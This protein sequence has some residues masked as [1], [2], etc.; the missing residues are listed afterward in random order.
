MRCCV[1]SRA[2]AIRSKEYAPR[3]SS[4]PPPLTPT[5]PP[6]PATGKEC[7]IIDPVDLTVGRDVQLLQEMGLKPAYA[8][9]THA[10]A[11]HITGT[12]APCGAIVIGVLHRREDDVIWLVD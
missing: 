1:A 10:H 4:S 7:I 2:C 5:P 9:N 6:P 8:L 12:G 11:D 3:H